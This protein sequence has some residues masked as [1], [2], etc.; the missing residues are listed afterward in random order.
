[1]PNQLILMI[2]DDAD[3]REPIVSALESEGYEVI[4][5]T[6][7]KAGLELLQWGVVPHV[8]LLDLLMP[9]MDGWNFRHH[10]LAD[11]A[12]AAI[13]VIVL[14]ADPRASRLAGSPGVH[15]VLLKPVHLAVLLESLDRIGTS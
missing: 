6:D 12:L 1:V 10:Q 2:E 15:A 13:P 3:F 14:S 7:G 8:I 5:A 9:V 4:V 11:P